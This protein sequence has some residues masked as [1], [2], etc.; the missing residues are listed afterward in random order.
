VPRRL[1]LAHRGHC[2]D[3]PEQTLL[4]FDRAAEL[5]ATVLEADLRFSADGVALMMHDATL[6]RTTSGQGPVAAMDWAVIA[7]LDAGAWF[8]PRFAGERVPRLE[9]LFELA[10][11][12]GVG[13]CLEAKG[14]AGPEN[15][16]AAL[17]AARKIARR[18]R[19]EIDV[20]ASFDHDALAAAAAAVPGLRIA[21][22]RLP[23]R[24]ASTAAGLL[25]QARRISAPI[26]QHHF[27][28]LAPAVAAEVQAA[29]VALWV[30]PPASWVEAEAAYATGAIGL[31]GDD[32]AALVAVVAEAEGG[33]A[34]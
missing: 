29:G 22:D 18:G 25:A 11:R 33:P 6:D 21:P 34:P 23:E 20:V 15:L 32:V 17:H 27:A 14:G 10:E 3:L 30:W 13:L 12:R 2:V 5:G 8:A 7:R 1:I 19:L 9:E 26:V 24:G 4:A 31:M 16:R 28:D